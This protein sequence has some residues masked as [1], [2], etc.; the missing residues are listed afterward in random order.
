[1]F[2]RRPEFRLIL[3]SATIEPSL[4]CSYYGINADAAIV[5]VPGR[6]YPVDVTYE[7]P[8]ELDELDEEDDTASISS[9]HSSSDG[10]VPR[11]GKTKDFVGPTVAKAI[12]L[13]RQLQDVGDILVFLPTPDDVNQACV[14]R[15]SDIC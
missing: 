3:A 13:H 5:R 15:A 10:H 7:Y 12:E 1:M 14:S 6:T 11:L 8:D 2:H 4:F 9:D